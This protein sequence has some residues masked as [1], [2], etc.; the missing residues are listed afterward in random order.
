M[1]SILNG[2][3]TKNNIRL[4]SDSLLVEL[5]IQ[6]LNWGVVGMYNF[7]DK[8]YLVD[9]RRIDITFQPI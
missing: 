2:F 8:S 1:K 5:E 3:V 7:R 4:K 6:H 9:N